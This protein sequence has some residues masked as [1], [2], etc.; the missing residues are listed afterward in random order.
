M[1]RKIHKLLWT[2]CALLGLIW[3]ANAFAQ[4]S[5]YRVI[6]VIAENSKGRGVTLIKDTVTSKVSAF[7]QGMA[8][9]ATTKVDGVYGR[10]VILSTNDQKV[11]LKIGDDLPT[12]LDGDGSSASSSNTTVEGGI[13]REGSTVR[14]QAS[15]KNH[16]VG[17][18]LSKVLTQAASEPVWRNGSLVG[19]SLWDIEKGSIFEAAGFQN[20]DIITHI[21]NDTIN[22]AGKAIRILNS[23][24][25]ATQAEISII[26]NNQPQNITLVIQ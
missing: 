23:L 2:T 13:S 11:R 12:Q 4:G 8:I 10:Y 18:N 1:L 15:L 25:G 17:E 24:R 19:F 26:R 3:Q 22:D 6:G 5:R 14:I 21:N 20:G 9:D 16:L 7:R